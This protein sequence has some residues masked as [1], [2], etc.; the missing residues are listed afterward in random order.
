MLHW[1]YARRSGSSPTT[2]LSSSR[3]SRSCAAAA[4]SSDGERIA[5]PQR[6]YLG[7][8]L[9][10]AAHRVLYG[11]LTA[12]ASWFRAKRGFERIGAHFVPDSAA[13][14]AA[15]AAAMAPLPEEAHVANTTSSTGI[16]IIQP[17]TGEQKGSPPRREATEAPTPEQQQQ[18]QQAQ[19][20]HGGAGA[21]PLGSGK[22]K[23]CRPGCVRQ[24]GCL[25]C[26]GVLQSSSLTARPRK[27]SSRWA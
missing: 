10:F 26:F 12:D 23:S 19:G 5:P 18:R 8:E 20:A 27:P 22:A 2:S 21:S 6:R 7:C 16:S 17:P 4:Q 9:W 11:C 13:S 1:R 24:P 14:A 3:S 25:R 15:A